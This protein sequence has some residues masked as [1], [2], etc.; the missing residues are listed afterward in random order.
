MANVAD[1][2]FSS[3]KSINSLS[4]Y[5]VRVCIMKCGAGDMCL[6]FIVHNLIWLKKLSAAILDAKRVKKK[7]LHTQGFQ[8][9]CIKFFFRFVSL[10]RLW[11]ARE[12]D[13]ISTHN[14]FEYREEYARASFSLIYFHAYIFHHQI[15]I[16]TSNFVVY[17]IVFRTHFW[18][19][20][21]GLI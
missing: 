1:D 17:D 16:V 5:D 20:F 15:F 13:F 19:V 9:C 10:A 7:P 8:V 11:M 12:R 21:H 2:T 14:N 18:L 3:I 6:Y 4:H